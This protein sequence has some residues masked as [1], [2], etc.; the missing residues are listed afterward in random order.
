MREATTV[1]RGRGRRL[2]L[3]RPAGLPS[4]QSTISLH[5][6]ES[7]LSPHLLEKALERLIRD[8]PPNLASLAHPNE[9][10]LDLLRELGSREGYPRY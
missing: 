6:S 7:C 9:E 1:G 2:T 10:V 5:D 4:A 3:V 8:F